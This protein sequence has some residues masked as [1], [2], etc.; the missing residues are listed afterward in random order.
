M[1]EHVEDA[2][3]ALFERLTAASR[4]A[5]MVMSSINNALHGSCRGIPGYVA[6]MSHTAVHCGEPASVARR[7][8]HR[9]SLAAAI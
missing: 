5:A 2:D 6:R 4:T 3:N 7:S 8:K 9:P 1:S